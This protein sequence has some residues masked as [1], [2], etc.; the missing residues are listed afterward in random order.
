MIPSSRP[1]PSC[2]SLTSSPSPSQENRESGPRSNCLFTC[3]SRIVFL[4]KPNLKI[5]GVMMD[6]RQDRAKQRGER[7]TERTR[8]DTAQSTTQ[9]RD[10]SHYPVTADD[11]RNFGSPQGGKRQSRKYYIVPPPATPRQCHCLN[12]K[13]QIQPDPKPKDP[14]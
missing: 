4:A 14:K 3:D 10:L 11:S 7:K 12:A 5:R 1:L 2:L 9:G 6:Q 8:E 13:Q